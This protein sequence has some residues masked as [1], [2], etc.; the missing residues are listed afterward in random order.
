[1]GRGKPTSSPPRDNGIRTGPTPKA[2]YIDLQAF[3]SGKAHEESHTEQKPK[4]Q[5]NS[6]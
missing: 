4:A 1:M 5:L 6:D 2:S 3:T